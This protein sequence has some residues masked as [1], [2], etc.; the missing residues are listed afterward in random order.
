MEHL[1]LSKML[2]KYN[3]VCTFKKDGDDLVVYLNQRNKSHSVDNFW[4]EF[5]SILSITGLKDELVTILMSSPYADDNPND[6]EDLGDYN[7]TGDLFKFKGELFIKACT[8]LEM[9]LTGKVCI[10]K[11]F[12]EED[13]FLR[14]F[15]YYPLLCF[16]EWDCILTTSDKD[17]RFENTNE[18]FGA[19]T[20]SI[21]LLI[22][23]LL[24]RKLVFLSVFREKD[25]EDED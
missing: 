16:D 13:T 19:P 1:I 21:G 25:D 24:I 18:E 9:K 22:P 17:Y 14:E 12:S 20:T 8:F 23:V 7:F 5:V 2:S 11:N 3:N 10:S 4:N 15:K 6:I